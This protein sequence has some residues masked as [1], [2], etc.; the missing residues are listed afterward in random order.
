[1]LEVVDVRDLRLKLVNDSGF[2]EALAIVTSLYVHSSTDCSIRNNLVREKGETRAT[3]RLVFSVY[4]PIRDMI[5]VNPVLYE[6]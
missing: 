2:P 6:K 5:I 1:M 4:T 3:R